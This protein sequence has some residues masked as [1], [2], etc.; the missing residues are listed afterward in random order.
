V[1]RFMMDDVRAVGTPGDP[2]GNDGIPTNGDCEFVW[3]YLAPRRPVTADIGPDESLELLPPLG[4]L[5]W[6]WGYVFPSW[7]KPQPVVID[8][9]NPDTPVVR[10][11]IAAELADMMR[12]ETRP[13]G[14][15]QLRQYY[16]AISS[17]PGVRDYR[18]IQPAAD[19]TSLIG[20][21]IT[22]GPISYTP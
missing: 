11:A 21:I 4:P 1:M 19:V 18:L 6:G 2:Q 17:A 20:E 10:A 22:L 7:P 14:T 15:L 13:G 8:G 16:L 3:N 9:L 12:H 5:P